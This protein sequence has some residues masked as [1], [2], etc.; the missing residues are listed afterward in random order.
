M[1]HCF[2]SQPTEVVLALEPSTTLVWT[3]GCWHAT[4]VQTGPGPRRT[5]CW[6]YGV[7]ERSRR[8]DLDVLR[9]VFDGVWQGWSEERKRLCE[10]TR[11]SYRWHLGCILPK[12]PAISLWAGGLDDG[13]EDHFEDG[14]GNRERFGES[15]W[16]LAKL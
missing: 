5:I 16:E 8:R 4:E 9:R 12:V 3:P 11:Y 14:Q 1:L 6:N 7:R 10:S 15:G 13:Y 2:A